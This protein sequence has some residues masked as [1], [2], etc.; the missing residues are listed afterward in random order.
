MQKVIEKDC[1]LEKVFCVFC[2]FG[3]PRFISAQL[4][5]FL[6]YLLWQGVIYVFLGDISIFDVSN[7][8]YFRDLSIILFALPYYIFFLGQLKK[9]FRATTHYIDLPQEESVR[10]LNNFFEKLLSDKRFVLSGLIF[11]GYYLTLTTVY[12]ITGYY[13][14][15]F[16]ISRLVVVLGLFFFGGFVYQFAYIAKFMLKR[17]KKLPLKKDALDEDLSQIFILGFSGGFAWFV[18][19]L[20]MMLPA[21]MLGFNPNSLIWYI[22]FD[23]TIFMIG[24]SFF[25]II[26]Y[27]YLFKS[28]ELKSR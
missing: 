18:V 2:R 3:L 17:F 1:I 23:G 16:Y 7:I 21:L 28:R 5:S 8:F 24:I 27:V 22:T 4:V 9:V 12:V 11:S 25:V 20:I 10:L 19:L 6:L 13:S 14:I 15:H 26:T